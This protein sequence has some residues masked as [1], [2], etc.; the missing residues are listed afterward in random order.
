MCVRPQTPAASVAGIVWLDSRSTGLLW[1]GVGA[2]GVLVL[3]VAGPL[4]AQARAT[5]TPYVFDDVAARHTGTGE[6]VVPFG[7]GLAFLDDY[8]SGLE[9]GTRLAGFTLPLDWSQRVSPCPE[10][11]GP[12]RST[13]AFRGSGA[14]QPMLWVPGD[15]PALCPGDR[16]AAVVELQR[17]LTEKRL[18]REELT[19]VYDEATRYAVITFHKLLGPSHADPRTA[20]A[21]WIADPPPDDWNV[22]DWALLLAFDPRPPSYRLGQPDRVEID[23]GHQVL[24][25]VEDHEV[26]ALMPVSTGKGRGTVGCVEEGCN[27]NV[28]PRTTRFERGS[29]FNYQH[30]YGRGWSPRP[31]EWSIYKGIFY[32]GNYGEWN[33]GLHGYRSVP[34]YPASHG[35]IR[36]TLWDMDYLRPWEGPGVYAQEARVWIGMPIHVWDEL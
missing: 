2:A 21:D 18:Y 26:A 14:L 36:L 23:I 22:D 4:S 24:Y 12:Q 5:V 30:M 15:R 32:R 8:R 33:Y 3:L 34:S 20:V 13:S 29:R 9:S 27:A 11:D 6:P 17:L 31:A 35:C 28:T 16:S 1:R 25:L 10:S 19:G 7:G